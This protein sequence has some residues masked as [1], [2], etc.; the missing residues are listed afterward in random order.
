MRISR[1]QE[2]LKWIENSLKSTESRMQIFTH[3]QSS[4][5]ALSDLHPCKLTLEVPW[6]FAADTEQSPTRTDIRL[7]GN[8]SRV[9]WLLRDLE[10]RCRRFLL[11][12]PVDSA[13]RAAGT[14]IIQ[15]QKS[16][17]LDFRNSE[18]NRSLPSLLALGWGAPKL[19]LSFV[20][21]FDRI[22][23]LLMQSF[24]FF[25]FFISH[26]SLQSVSEILSSLSSVCHLRAKIAIIQILNFISGWRRSNSVQFK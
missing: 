10:C 6:E 14:E 17:N 5:R 12:S 15:G 22:R 4:S 2:V 3:C 8:T 9:R 23:H 25:R 24:Q 7:R 18:F 21:L 13:W 16:I 1:M 11:S 19:V 26:C 20:S